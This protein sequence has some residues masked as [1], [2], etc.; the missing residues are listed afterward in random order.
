MRHP[1]VVAKNG[2]AFAKVFDVEVGEVAV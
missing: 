1:E 2:V